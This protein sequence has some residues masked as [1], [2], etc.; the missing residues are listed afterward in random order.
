[1]AFNL[2]KLLANNLHGQGVKIFCGK[3]LRCPFCIAYTLFDI[4]HEDDNPGWKK[5]I[6]GLINNSTMVSSAA[7]LSLYLKFVCSSSFTWGSV[8]CFAFF[9]MKLYFLFL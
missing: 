4:F 5:Q 2:Q 6:L 1:M 8:R 9:T 7:I 3:A